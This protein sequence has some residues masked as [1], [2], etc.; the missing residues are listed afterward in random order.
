MKKIVKYP[1][2]ILRKPAEEVSDLSSIID[3]VEEMKQTMVSAG[4]I[5]T[6]RE[7]G[8]SEVRLS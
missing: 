1:S 7:G 4:G 6:G 5:G 8:V 2:E 3:L